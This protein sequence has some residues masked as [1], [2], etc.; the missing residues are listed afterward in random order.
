MFHVLCKFFPGSF[1]SRGFAKYVVS[2]L[3]LL[4]IVWCKLFRKAMFISFFE[5]FHNF[6]FTMKNLLKKDLQVNVQSSWP[7]AKSVTLMCFAQSLMLGLSFSCRRGEFVGTLKNQTSWVYRLLKDLLSILM[8]CRDYISS[9][10]NYMMI[11]QLMVNEGISELLFTSDGVFQ[12]EQKY[13]PE[14]PGGK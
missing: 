3:I 6:I 7:H 13:F 5:C 12:M 2:I 10:V 4:I 1:Y 9:N 11:F 14:L 8:Q